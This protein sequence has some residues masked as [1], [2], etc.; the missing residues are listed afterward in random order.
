MEISHHHH[1]EPIIAPKEEELKFTVDRVQY[2]LSKDALMVLSGGMDSVTLLYEYRAR[3]ALA[4][5]FNYGSNHNRLE[6]ECA[7]WHCRNLGIEHLV[8]PLDFMGQYFRSSLLEGADAI[9]A[10]HYA[11]ENM[12]STVVPFRNGIML[13]IAAGLAESRNL[14]TV[15]LANHSGDH[16][17]YPDCR[18]QFVEAMGAAI[19]AGTYEPVRLECPYTGI[20]KN[21]IV[22]RGLS[23]GVDY[24]RTYSC[25]RGLPTHC[26]TCGTCTERHEALAAAG[27][28]PT[29]FD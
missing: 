17:I 5:T 29:D 27:L 20:S 2:P 16:A 19:A 18:P 9:P 28:N 22:R 23:L 4:V 3:V 12:R 11:D 13:A 24:R 21:D 8:I 26:G 6:A 10:G 7:A 14:R 25:Y 1:A 15:M